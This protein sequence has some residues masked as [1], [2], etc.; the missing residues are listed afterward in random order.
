MVGYPRQQVCRKLGDNRHWKLEAYGGREKFK[1]DIY[2]WDFRL[3]VIIDSIY[4]NKNSQESIQSSR[5]LRMHDEATFK[6][7]SEQK[8]KMDRF[9]YSSNHSWI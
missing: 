3:L 8:E 5:K 9:S 1:T 2:T 6:L 7:G 4:L